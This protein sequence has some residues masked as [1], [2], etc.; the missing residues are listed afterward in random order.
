VEWLPLAL[1]LSLSEMAFD[2][3]Q[4]CYAT[5]MV[6]AC[7][8]NVQQRWAAE[9]GS[10]RGKCE[11]DEWNERK[12]ADAVQVTITHC[13]ISSFSCSGSGSGSGR[14]I[15][16]P[17]RPALIKGYNSDIKGLVLNFTKV[18]VTCQCTSIIRVIVPNL[19][20]AACMTTIAFTCAL[21]LQGNE[22]NEFAEGKIGYLRPQQQ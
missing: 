12:T 11:A 19:P 7:Q 14:I 8:C 20:P 21:P 3:N 5:G 15:T 6:A 4:G 17:R 1:A 2:L 18:P 13:N 16:L 10:W 22:F 9:T